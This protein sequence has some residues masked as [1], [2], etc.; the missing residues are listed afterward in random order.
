MPSKYFSEHVVQPRVAS[1]AVYNQ[2]LPR[3]AENINQTLSFR[4]ESEPHGIMSQSRISP[5]PVLNEN[6]FKELPN[7][8]LTAADFVKRPLEPVF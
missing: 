3:A 5:N 8:L 6:G 2:H 7:A 4:N 1:N